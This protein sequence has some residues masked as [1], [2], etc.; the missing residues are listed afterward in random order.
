MRRA[1]CIG[2]TFVALALGAGHA[3]AQCTATGF[4]SNCALTRSWSVVVQRTVRVTITPTV[5]TLTNPDASDFTNGFSIAF[6][7]TAVIKANSGCQL[8]ISSTQALWTAS[9]GGRTNKPQADLR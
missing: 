6:G 4:P 8:L 1:R 9:G 2:A 7:H 3:R 5:A